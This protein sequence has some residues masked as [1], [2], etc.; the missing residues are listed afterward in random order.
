MRYASVCSGIE[1]CSVAWKPLGWECAWVSEIDAF[2]C[3]VL[4]DRWPGVPNLGDITTITQKDLERHGPIDL[5]VGGTP[6]QSF[7]FAGL[8]GGL[9]DARGNLALRFIQLVLLTRPRWVVWENVDGVL[10]AD[11]GR[12]FGSIVGGLA[13]CGYGWAYRILD[14]QHVRVDGFERAV[15]QRRNRV[16]LVGHSGA[17]WGRA[18]AVLFE[19]HCL[20]G[21]PPP[22]REARTVVTHALTRGLGTGGADVVHGYSNWLIPDDGVAGTLEART[23]A[24]GFPG[25]GGACNGHIVAEIDTPV[26]FGRNDCRGP[27]DSSGA[28]LAKNDRQDFESET[29]I[30][31]DERQITSP[32]NR[33]RC[34]PGGIAPTLH[35]HPLGIAGPIAVDLSN[36]SL[37]GEVSGTV[38]AAQDRHNRGP[39]VLEG[40]DPAT[41]NWQGA[42][43]QTQLGFDPSSGVAGTLHAHQVPAIAGRRPRVRR[44]TPTE[45]ERLMAFPDGY[46][47]IQYRGGTAKDSPRYKALGNSMAV[48]VVRWLGRR[49]DMVERIPM[50]ERS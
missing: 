21:D 26:A 1:A 48:N 38:L 6:C 13:E 28:I 23:K 29:F 22:R 10:S 15:P 9:D 27:I 5:L 37:G 36:A 46:T 42:G 30:V 18:A 49:I 14:A 39:A 4:A 34:D 40:E 44:I 50:K 45:A 3:A 25:T 43:R 12:A 32:H 41:F 17:D 2:P 47:A 8:R 33:S 16:F 7:S 11:E 35:T 31:F 24:G 20:R 19:R